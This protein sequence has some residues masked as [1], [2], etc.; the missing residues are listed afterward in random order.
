[1]GSKYIKGKDGKFKGS[2]SD[3]RDLPKSLS[4]P[5]KAPIP[6]AT[7]NASENQTRF[8]YNYGMRSN[9]RNGDAISETANIIPIR[10]GELPACTDVETFHDIEFMRDLDSHNEITPPKAYVDNLNWSELYLVQRGAIIGTDRDG[11]LN[12]RMVPGAADYDLTSAVLV[13][14]VK[15]KL[16]NPTFQGV[17]ENDPTPYIYVTK[18]I[19]H[20]A[21]IVKGSH[22][23]Y[24]PFSEEEIDAASR[25]LDS[26]FPR[27][28]VISEKTLNPQIVSKDASGYRLSSAADVLLAAGERLGK[29]ESVAKRLEHVKQEEKSP[30]GK[31]NADKYKKEIYRG[32]FLFDPH[33]SGRQLDDE[34]SD[35]LRSPGFYD[36]LSE[37]DRQYVLDTRFP[38]PSKELQARRK[39]VVEARRETNSQSNNR[40]SIIERLGGKSQLDTRKEELVNQQA[41]LESDPRGWVVK[42]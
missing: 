6:N 12:A 15:A 22:P 37:R 34:I 9:S 27:G 35:P 18:D 21:Q 25:V 29:D 26:S 16:S 1:M 23:S 3:G 30:R 17:D 40:K 14:N 5:R 10:D 39:S 36:R 19:T 24:S 42:Y 20:L 38:S 11:D 13:E 8:R 7:G 28:T 33:A 31:E 4:L 2:V 32:R 41:S